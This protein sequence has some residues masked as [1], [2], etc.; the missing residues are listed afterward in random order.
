MIRTLFR[1]KEDRVFKKASASA[2]GWKAYSQWPKLAVAKDSKPTGPSV[3]PL[4]VTRIRFS[5][6][7]GL[8]FFDTPV[9]DT[10][11]FRLK[12]RWQLQAKK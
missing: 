8:W 5:I 2:R 11:I 7:R 4:I 3:L 12:V 6:D 9:R 1:R 10:S